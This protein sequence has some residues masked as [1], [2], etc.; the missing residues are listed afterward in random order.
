MKF[1][2]CLLMLSIIIN[3][4]FDVSLRILEC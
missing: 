2:S 3:K 1:W 4:L